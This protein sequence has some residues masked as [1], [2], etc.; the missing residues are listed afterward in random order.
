[1]SISPGSRRGGVLPWIAA[2]GL[3]LMT[4]RPA[5][6]QIDCGEAPPAPPKRISG[7]EGFPPLPLPATPLRRTER[8]RP[9]A[10]PTL[11]AKVNSAGQQVDYKGHTVWDWTTAVGDTPSLFKY[12]R[13]VLD[14]NYKADVVRLDQFDYAPERVPIMYF[15]SRKA[16]EISPQEQALL[17]NYVLNGGAILGAASSG[18]EEFSSSF[19]EQMRQIFPDR[20]W[21][22]LPS[23]P[24]RGL[25]RGGAAVPRRP[26]LR[27]GQS[28]ARLRLPRD[29]GRREETRREYRG[30]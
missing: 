8:K 4:E 21:Y 16:M 12:L 19:V 27:L 1:M 25:P 7:G 5:N 17:R 29:A 22:Q 3:L 2:I 14:I 6:A 30:L 24:E 23:D 13:G 10:P 11:M 15:T 28:H 20:P 18:Y 9:P 26:E